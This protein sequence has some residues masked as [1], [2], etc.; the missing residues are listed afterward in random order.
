MTSENHTS[1][2]RRIILTILLV[3]ALGVLL[4]PATG[5][6]V[7]DGNESVS[8]A[9]FVLEQPDY[10]SSPVQQQSENGL[11]VYIVEGGEIHLQPQNFHSDEVTGFG[12]TTGAGSLHYDEKWNRY[13]LEADGEVGSFHIY[14]DVREEIEVGEGNDTTTQTRQERYEAIVRVDDMASVTVLSDA[15][16]VEL[17]EDAREWRHLNATLSEIRDSDMLGHLLFEPE[18]NQDVLQGMINAY[19]MTR[20]PFHLL[21]GGFSAS[22][23]ILTTTIGGLFLLSLL[24]VP[25]LFVLWRFWG[26][27]RRRL[28]LEEHEGD[29]AERQEE[30]D[31]EHRLTKVANWDWQDLPSVTDHEAYEFRTGVADNP[32]EGLKLLIYSFAPERLKEYQ[33][34]AMGQSGYVAQRIDPDDRAATD[35][36]TA[37]RVVHT[38]TVLEPGETV[39]DRSD[40]EPLTD[41]DD[42]LVAAI[43]LDDPEVREFDVRDAEFDPTDI[44]RELPTL[45]LPT[46]IEQFDFSEWGFQNDERIGEIFLE[47]IEHI[48]DHPVTN[49]DGSIDELRLQ[50]EQLLQIM[51]FASDSAQFPLADVL[52]QH[53]EFAIEHYD[54]D[55]ELREFMRKHRNSKNDD[56]E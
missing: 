45:D 28:R 13:T 21:D 16:A 38:D 23:I 32:L 56:D 7:A 51:R 6:V 54:K 33:L 11:P 52:S 39:A 34:L 1:N 2:C 40:L 42:E 44:D 22:I 50:L 8:S 41:P 30:L 31:I 47:F 55:D 3:V 14:F 43:S 19:L 10:V 46:L 20:S 4:L 26:D 18:T 49:E 9:E 15:R 17:E 29:L 36:G 53:F 5:S 37:V 48:N 12:L 27:F 24:L 25:A 35:G